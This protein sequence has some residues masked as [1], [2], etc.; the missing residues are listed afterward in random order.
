MYFTT[1]KKNG[2]CYYRFDL[3]ATCRHQCSIEIHLLFRACHLLTA[4]SLDRPGW[5]SLMVKNI[6][7]SIFHIA[8]QPRAASNGRLS[9]NI[10]WRLM[11]RS[12]KRLLIL[13]PFGP[14]FVSQSFHYYHLNHNARC[15][16]YKPPSTSF[17]I[18]H[19]SSPDSLT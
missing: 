17:G 13:H 14:K 16:D 15:S 11:P 1:I 10:L 5:P 6:R 9:G 3:Y 2:L 19:S 18:R 4:R 8:A 7:L 12:Q